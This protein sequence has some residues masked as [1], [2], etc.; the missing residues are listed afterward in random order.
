MT[1]L[2]I[3]ISII[4]GILFLLFLIIVIRK[5]LNKSNNSKIKSQIKTLQEEKGIKGEI[6]VDTYLKELLKDNEY[7]LT[8]LLIPYNKNNDKTEIDAILITHKGVF[9]I[10]IK[11]WSGI[12]YGND[13][14]KY[15]YQ[16]LNDSNL[17]K[18]Q[19]RNPVKQNEN[20]CEIVSRTIKNKNII[21]NNVVIFIKINDYKNIHSNHVYSL[22]DF[23][24][25]YKTLPDSCKDNDF[26]EKIYNMLS[27]YKA[28]E[29]ELNKHKNKLQNK[30]K[31]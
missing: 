20:H 22:L 28:S 12:I 5:S 25:I 18:N 1:F 27:K 23:I 17:N 4:L 11:N 26:L 8:N 30:Y 31:D 29:E 19:H 2:I 21:I 6:I 14:D 15:W 16:K 24:S 7:L 10:E 9:C 3:F 13:E